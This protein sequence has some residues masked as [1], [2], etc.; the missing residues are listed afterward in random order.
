MSKKDFKLFIKIICIVCFIVA[1]LFLLKKV[2][3]TSDNN[4]SQKSFYESSEY[5][6]IINE[7]HELQFTQQYDN[8][9]YAYLVNQD[10]TIVSKNKIASYIYSDDIYSDYDLCRFVSSSNHLIGYMNTHGEICIP[11]RFITAEK[12]SN[13]FAVV[14]EDANNGYFYIDQ[15]GNKLN[16]EHYQYCDSFYNNIARVEKMDGSWSIITRDNTTVVEN[17][18]SINELPLFYT[19]LT[20]IRD[21][22]AV[23]IKLDINGEV[24]TTKV[25]DDSDY[26]SAPA[27]DCFAITKN[28]TGYGVVDLLSGEQVI[29]NAYEEI[30]YEI[31]DDAQWLGSHIKFKC[32][33]ANHGYEFIEKRF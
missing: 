19:N 12:M 1:V 28:K 11:A 26:I 13:G 15:S 29:P 7:P 8:A 22:K 4:A 25:L 30:D 20:G 5:H 18:D 2:I 6:E 3:L 27:F 24:Y 33:S 16:E 17:Y 9:G 32:K 23:I 14:S 10:G 31:I 21:Q